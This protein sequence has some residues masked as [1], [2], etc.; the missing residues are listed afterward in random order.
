MLLADSLRE[1]ERDVTAPESSDD[2]TLST[3]GES[4]YVAGGDPRTQPKTML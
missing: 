2:P 4:A 1:N 3:E